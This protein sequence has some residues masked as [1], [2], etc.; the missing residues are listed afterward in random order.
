MMRLDERLPSTGWWWVFVLLIAAPAAALAML[1]AST[2]RADEIERQHVLQQQKARTTNLIGIAVAGVSARAMEHAEIAFEVDSDAT[3]FFPRH[4]VHTGASSLVS[5]LAIPPSD[6][7]ELAE[8]ARDADAQGLVAEAARLYDEVIRRGEFADW[9]RAQSASLAAA[10]RGAPPYVPPA[11]MAD[12]EA[13]TPSGVPLALALCAA[14]EV[15]TPSELRRLQ[16][17]LTRTHQNLRAGRWWMSL[18]ERRSY[19]SALIRWRQ[20]IDPEATAADGDGELLAEL[21][22]VAGAVTMALSDRRFGPRAAEIA[23]DGEWLLLWNPPAHSGRR[24]SGAALPRRAWHAAVDRALSPLVTGQPFSVTLWHGSTRVWSSASAPAGSRDAV[25]LAAF[26]GWSVSLDEHSIVVP[27]HVRVQRVGRVLAP[28]VLLAC[29]LAM[30]AWIIR[31]EMILRDTQERLVASVTHE[32]KSPLTSVSL[33]T[34]RL[35]RHAD[36]QVAEYA[37]A[38][39]GE[40]QRLG[41]LV[42]RMLEVQQLRA[43]RRAYVFGWTDLATLVEDVARVLRPHAEARGMT[44]ATRVASAVPP[45]SLDGNAIRDAIRNLI[46]N[47]IK[48]SPPGSHVDVVVAAGARHVHVAVI[49]QGVGVDPADA[50]RIFD[51]FYRGHRGDDAN[52]RGTGLG[53]ALVKATA[54]AHGGEV[55]VDSDGRRGSRFTL[56]L[57][58]DSPPAVRSATRASRL[59]RSVHSR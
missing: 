1:G 11:A 5:P 21:Q 32:F 17:L 31:R 20:R 55:S 56:T 58:I 26:P 49:D 28:L 12:S 9:A 22:R 30:T 34:E 6:S 59:P 4:R 3:V 35:V 2:W 38:M 19:D 24:W 48:Y 54:A 44:V 33:L 53:L 8:R 37:R 45:L 41:Q 10:S 7:Y 57:P 36:P 46:D 43:G 18:D 42:D 13:L 23:P 16:P 15:A 14:A 51:E 40:A 39:Q 27:W 29:G 25:A 50:D 52:V 47:A